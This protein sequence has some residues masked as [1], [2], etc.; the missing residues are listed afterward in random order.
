M[1]SVISRLREYK[2]NIELEEK[3][4]GEV[5]EEVIEEIWK[6]GKGS[7]GDTKKGWGIRVQEGK[8]EMGQFGGGGWMK[9]GELHGKGVRMTGDRILTGSFSNG[10]LL[11][12]LI[13]WHDGNWYFGECTSKENRTGDVWAYGHGYYEYAEYKDGKREGRWLRVHDNGDEEEEEYRAH[14]QVGATILRKLSAL[15][16]I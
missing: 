11:K 7:L 15:L 8:I 14:K 12:Y 13:T 16:D 9:E 4:W 6:V 3:Y 10:S 2:R 5:M 1:K